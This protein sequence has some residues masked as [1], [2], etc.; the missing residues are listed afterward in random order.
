MMSI[1]IEKQ[2]VNI[3]WSHAKKQPSTGIGKPR[4]GFGRKPSIF[5]TKLLRTLKWCIINCVLGY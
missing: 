5:F 2:V 1:D 4:I 3:V